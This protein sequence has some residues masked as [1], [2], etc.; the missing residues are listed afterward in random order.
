MTTQEIEREI[1]ACKKAAARDRAAA[2]GVENGMS[3]ADLLEM[4][5]NVVVVCGGS[6]MKCTSVRCEAANG[7]VWNPINF[8]RVR[9]EDY[10]GTLVPFTAEEVDGFMGVL[11]RDGIVTG[12]PFD[13]R[14]AIE[15]RPV[16]KERA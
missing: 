10:E 15:E 11:K 9:L 14:K 16:S 6:R 1:E 5:K 12:K 2:K 3:S 4:L 8:S 7:T 13:V